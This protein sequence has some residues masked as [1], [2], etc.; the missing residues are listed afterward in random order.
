[1]RG[2]RSVIHLPDGLTR[3]YYEVTCA[4]GTQEL[5]TEVVG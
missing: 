3:A 5:H 1:L 2:S 4:D